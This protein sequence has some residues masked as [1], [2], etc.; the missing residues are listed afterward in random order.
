MLNIGLCD[1]SYHTKQFYSFHQTGLSDYLFRL[2]TEGSCE[3]IVNDKNIVI[4]KGDLLLIKPGDHY[5][6][7]VEEGQNSGDY[8]LFCKGIWIDEWWNRSA[9][10]T[11][12]RIDLDEKLLTLWRHIIIEE[13]R[14]PSE[15]NNEL[16]GY[17]LRALC[18]SLERTVNETSSTFSRPYAVTIMMRFIE[19]HAL[20][21]FKIE[22]VA[23]HA[24]LSVSRAV[25]LFK[26]S[27]GKT[28]IEYAQEIRLSAA[29]DQM[30]YTIM[31][32][33]QIAE[34]CGFGGYPYFHKVFKKKYGVSPGNFRRKE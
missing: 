30:K 23:Q 15:E 24:G 17:L 1:Y 6:L 34:N 14:P 16:I 28:M 32:L 3:V 33:D 9:K 8:Y 5:E 22:E 10:P 4:E 18:L 2:Q 26:S 21:A 13:R 27:V 25:H 19:E 31:T 29:I 20:I 12:S 11:V 7:R